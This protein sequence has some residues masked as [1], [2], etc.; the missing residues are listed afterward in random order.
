MLDAAPYRAGFS[1]PDRLRADALSLAGGSVTIHA[2]TR[3]PAARCPLCGRRSD[4]IHGR[5]TRTL[6]DL[7]WCGMPVRLRVRVRKFFCDEP[8]C[9]RRIFAERLEG[10]ARPLARGTD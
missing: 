6:A 2:S 10:V 9:E 4:R 1:V 8:S 7:P 5:Y 3:D